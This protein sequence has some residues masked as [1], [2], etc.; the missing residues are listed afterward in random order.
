MINVM[1]M[2]RKS[3]FCVLLQKEDVLTQNP[4]GVN[5]S[6]LH[7]FYSS[8]FFFFDSIFKCLLSLILSITDTAIL[9]P[10]STRSK[11]HEDS[12]TLKCLLVHHHQLSAVQ[13]CGIVRP[14][15]RW[16]A[17]CFGKKNTRTMQYN[18]R[19]PLTNL[20]IKC[21]EEGRGFTGGLM[22]VE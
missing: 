10:S 12:T 5:C 7:C 13:S 14:I 1:R 8:F 17:T 22:C 9:L 15:I 18:S 21:A 2:N 3:V 6:T 19:F 4:I 20:I 16:P 11:L